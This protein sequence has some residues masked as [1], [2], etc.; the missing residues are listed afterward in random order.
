MASKELLLKVA[1]MSH[2]QLMTNEEI[3]QELFTE[4]VL[5]SRNTK[6]VRE[7]IDEAVVYLLD[8]QEA[9]ETA[10]SD[11]NELRLLEARLCENYELIDARVIAGGE[12]Q[13]VA[14]YAALVRRHGRA[15]AQY[16]DELSSEAED[17]SEQLHIAVSGGQSILDMVSSLAER[18]RPNAH[19]Y[20]TALI[21]RGGPKSSAHIGPETN[22]SVAWSRSGRIPHHLFYG[23]VPPYSFG[24][25]DF[26][27]LPKKELHNWIRDEIIRQGKSLAATDPVKQTLGIM[28]DSINMAIAGLGLVRPSPADADYGTGHLERI[29]M[30]SLLKTLQID[31]D[32]L[33]EEGACGE[34][35]YGL[36]D[37]K[38]RGNPL[39]NFFLTAGEGTAHSGVEFYRRLVD[40]GKKVI[41]IAGA[42]KWDALVPAI[43]ARLFN[44][45][46]TD[47]YTAERLLIGQA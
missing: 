15:A 25:E 14:E 41:V 6:R 43:N 42:K 33:S 46:I 36:F 19:F 31:L 28:S 21:G 20:A 38:G 13:G 22:A 32:L 47:A 16:F 40:Q 35:S 3:A 45:L 34:L 12:T 37:R 11:K 23:T 26:K 1:R 9:F 27:G 17:N 4:K 10:E 8:Q 30:T 24:P 7:L 39:W 18:R 2:A 5:T 29:T 44:I